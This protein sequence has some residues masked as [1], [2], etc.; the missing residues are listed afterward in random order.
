M[1]LV[2]I[3]ERFATPGYYIPQAIR[4]KANAASAA[5]TNTFKKAMA[6]GVRICLGTD[7]GVYPH[8]RNV[9]EFG[10]MVKLGMKPVEALKAGTSRDAELLGVADRLG[11]L[12][13]GKIAD[14]VAVPGDP[15]ADI[16]STERVFFVMKDGA[17]FRNDR[18]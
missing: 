1:A 9:E 5:V 4:D 3:Q 6:K 15:T 14:V 11:S 2:G 7:A 16:R 12:E 18:K 13:T 17:I 8:G 10:Q